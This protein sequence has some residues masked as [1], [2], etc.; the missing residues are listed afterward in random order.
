M[1]LLNLHAILC[2]YYFH[3]CGEREVSDPR[4]RRKD[5]EL[6]PQLANKQVSIPQ[7]NSGQ[8]IIAHLY[9]LWFDVESCSHLP[10]K[11][12]FFMWQHHLQQFIFFVVG[13]ICGTPFLIFAQGTVHLFLG[14]ICYDW[15]CCGGVMGILFFSEARVALFK[16]ILSRKSAVWSKSQGSE[17]RRRIHHVFA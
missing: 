2:V 13:F 10:E 7:T 5:H 11:Q 8:R 16:V 9:G 3:F 15:F 17:E 14:F 1:Q 4:P 6:P 12:Q